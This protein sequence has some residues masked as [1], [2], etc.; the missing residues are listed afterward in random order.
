MRRPSY[1]PSYK[2]ASVGLGFQRIAVL[3]HWELHT[4]EFYRVLNGK[5]PGRASK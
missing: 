1:K 5:L 4:D 3:D 2:T